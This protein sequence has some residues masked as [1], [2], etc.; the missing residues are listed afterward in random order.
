MS[1][2]SILA[3]LIGSEVPGGC[4]TCDAIQTV[5]RL[6]CGRVY[7]LTVAHD[8]SCPTLRAMR[9]RARASAATAP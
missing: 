9:K 5:Q 1:I 6:D 3:P 2:A 7:R 4:D 8:W